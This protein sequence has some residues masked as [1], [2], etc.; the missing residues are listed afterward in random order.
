MVTLFFTRIISQLNSDLPLQVCRQF[1]RRAGTGVS[2]DV[3]K[4]VKGRRLPKDDTNLAWRDPNIEILT[5]KCFPFFLPGNIGPAWYDTQTTIKSN[6]NFILNITEKNDSEIICK[7]QTCPKVLHETVSSLFPYRNMENSDL[8]VVT[9]SIRANVKALRKN[10][11]LETE[12]LAQAFILAAKNVC[13]KLRKGGYWADFINPF[14]GKPYFASSSGENL[15][16]TDEKFRCLD[17]QIFEIEKC[18]VIANEDNQSRRSLVG[19]LFTNAPS[20]LKQFSELFQV[21]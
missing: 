3:Y 4:A 13:I 7:V 10:N 17:F 9:I 14:S 18:L 12:R 6:A 11:E 16:S 20:K 21:E 1:S 8:S 2:K 19:S 5:S 15:Y